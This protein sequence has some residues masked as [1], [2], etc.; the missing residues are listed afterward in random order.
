MQSQ[1]PLD[2]TARISQVATKFLVKENLKMDGVF[3]LPPTFVHEQSLQEQL[4]GAF[5]RLDTDQSGSLD[6]AF[7]YV[8]GLMVSLINRFIL[9]IGCI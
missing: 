2:P 1:T 5:N 7:L 8:V 4:R 9:Y 6:K 3:P